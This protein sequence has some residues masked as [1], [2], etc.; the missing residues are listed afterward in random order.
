MS[1]RKLLMSLLITILVTSCR[2][3]KEELMHQRVQ[4]LSEMAELGTIEYTIKKIIKC[5]S[6]VWYKYGDRKILY[7]SV[8]YLKAGIDMSEFSPENV[9]IDKA[10]K[11]ITATFPKAKLLSM[12][13][14]LEL[15]KEEYCRV[16][17]LRDEFTTEERLLLKQQGEAAIRE[18]VPNLGI[19]E[20]AENS[21]KLFFE[22]MFSKFGYDKVIVNFENE[23]E[24]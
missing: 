19:L 14:P 1:T 16:T 8:A 17:G 23:Y 2:P 4:T 9:K 22:T 21:A 10:N 20:D 7:S 3:S 5:N 6:D 15:I 12:N 13:M 24:N 18:D 11:T